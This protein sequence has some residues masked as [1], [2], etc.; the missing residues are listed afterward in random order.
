MKIE[1]GMGG[2]YGFNGDR[3]PFTVIEVVSDKEIVIQ[4]DS[5]K[6]IELGA[7]YKEGPVKCEFFRNENALKMTLTFR[8]NGEWYPKGLAIRKGYS[9]SYYVGERIYSRNPHF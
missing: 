6:V 9:W 7:M 4:S 3:Y 8:K 2:F 5:Y 1:V